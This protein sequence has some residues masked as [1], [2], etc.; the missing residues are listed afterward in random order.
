MSALKHYMALDG[1]SGPQD[2][3]TL[4]I[5]HNTREAKKLVGLRYVCGR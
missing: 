3:A 1:P 4:V 2:G 5:A